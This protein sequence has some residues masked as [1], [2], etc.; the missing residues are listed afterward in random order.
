MYPGDAFTRQTAILEVLWRPREGRDIQRVQWADDAVSLGW[1]KGDDDLD[2][3]TTHFQLEASVGVVH[4]PGRHGIRGNNRQ[5]VA[6][7]W[8][9]EKVSIGSVVTFDPVVSASCMSSPRYDQVASQLV[10]TRQCRCNTLVLRDFGKGEG[11]KMSPDSAGES[12][13]RHPSAV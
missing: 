8:R 2:L 6:P 11:S 9:F 10:S 7:V 5:L 3:G 12:I 4:E 13:G 1:H